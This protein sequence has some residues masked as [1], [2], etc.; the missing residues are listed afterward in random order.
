MGS[1]SSGGHAAYIHAIG[2]VSLPEQTIDTTFM[3]ALFEFLHKMEKVPLAAAT[4]KV[5]I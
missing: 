2:D 1:Q 3:A 5:S 4:G